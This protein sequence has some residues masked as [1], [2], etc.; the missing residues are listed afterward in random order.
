MFVFSGEK[1]CT[2]FFQEVKDGGGGSLVLLWLFSSTFLSLQALL[3]SV[4][5]MKNMASRSLWPILAIPSPFEL[6]SY[7]YRM[8]PSSVF[9]KQ[10][11]EELSNFL[12]HLVSQGLGL[13]KGW[14]V[15]STCNL[16]Y[17]CI[18][19]DGVRFIH[20]HQTNTV[21]NLRK[22]LF[23]GKTKFINTNKKNADKQT[24]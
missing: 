15:V 9:P 14:D 6:I 21:S 16:P 1:K 12:V 11:P 13:V 2:I 3:K 22:Y 18:Y 4:K 5:W 17:M 7:T 10:S 8:S 19:W 23:K 24:S 20:W